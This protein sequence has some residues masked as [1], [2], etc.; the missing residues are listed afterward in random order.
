MATEADYNAGTVAAL[1]VEKQIIVEKGVPSFM[2]PSDDVLQQYA[3][4]VAKAVID[5]VDAERAAGVTS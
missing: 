5:A 3:A 4:Q 1:A 2:V